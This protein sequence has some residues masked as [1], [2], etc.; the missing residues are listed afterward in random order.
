[1]TGSLKANDDLDIVLSGVKPENVG[2]VV[3]KT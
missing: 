2:T 1:M 3:L